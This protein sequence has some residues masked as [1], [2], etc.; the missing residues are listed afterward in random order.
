M[1]INIDAS[2]FLSKLP[3]PYLLFET[4]LKPREEK[5]RCKNIIL[6]LFLSKDFHCGK[7][8]NNLVKD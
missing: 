6:F 3:Q 2:E 1:H 8:W 7:K 4:I 5:I